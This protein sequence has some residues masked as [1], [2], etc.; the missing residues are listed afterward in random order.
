MYAIND[1]KFR[2]NFR[3]FTLV[4][5][6]AVRHFIHCQATFAT[7]VRVARRKLELTAT[8]QCVTGFSHLIE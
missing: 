4:V 7:L 1:F 2:E 8:M 6:E 3:E 5:T